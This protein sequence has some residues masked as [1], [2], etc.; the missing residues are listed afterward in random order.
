MLTEEEWMKREV[1]GGKLLLT[2][3]EWLKKSSKG[4][5]DQKGRREVDNRGPCGG[6]DRTRI[7]C[8]NCN[9]LGHYASECRKPRKEK[10]S[11]VLANLTQT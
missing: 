4:T 5:M 2:R 10:E 6:R 9:L 11:K 8:F 7:R 3:E 1:Q